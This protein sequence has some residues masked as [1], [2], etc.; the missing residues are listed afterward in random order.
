M[1]KYKYNINNLDCASC[2]REIEEELN[3]NKKFNNVV[4]NFN[5]SKISYESE[6]EITLKELNC[7]VKKVEPDANVSSE[8]E[9]EGK[10]YHLSILIIAIIIGL[11]ANF[12]IKS[13]ILKTILFV[14]SYIL[15]LYRTTINAIKLLIKSRTINEN[16][17]ITISCVGAFFIGDALE[18]MM[19]IVLYTIGKILEE[20][21][22]NNSRK[23]IKDLLDIKS[24]YANKL[25]KNKVIKVEVEK[26]KVN[27]ILVVKKG[28]KIPVDGVITKGSTQLDTSALTGES[29]LITVNKKDKVLSASINMGDV[30]EIK[31]TSIF[32]DSTVSRIL[33]L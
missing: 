3:K 25:E 6:E 8:L 13:D 32:E 21:A 22:I 9:N 17:L 20:K 28:E 30:I 33:E 11:S 1:K 14:I 31:A 7:L 18:G 23:S 2:A 4:V 5:T 10:E 19:V 27:D 26:I 24:P 29:D 15:L 16:A 12:L